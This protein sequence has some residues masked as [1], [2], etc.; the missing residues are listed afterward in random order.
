MEFPSNKH[1]TEGE[2]ATFKIAVSGNPEPTL[3]WYHEGIELKSDYAVEIQLSGVLSIMSA[4]LKHS[5][6][7][8][9]Q[10]RNSSGTAEREVKLTVRPDNEEVEPN[11]KETVKLMPIPVTDFGEYVAVNHSHS[12]T[13]F[14]NQYEVV[15]YVS[16]ELDSNFQCVCRVLTVVMSILK[17]LDC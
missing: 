17:Q 4:E 13:G 12:D 9:L 8:K 5:G 10:A 14:R 15:T 1:L 11:Q 7:Y 16:I 2:S 3:T 6:V